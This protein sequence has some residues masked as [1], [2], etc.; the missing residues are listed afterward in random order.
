[1]LR[2]PDRNSAHAIL[3][4]R[5]SPVPKP[6]EPAVRM[7]MP[8]CAFWASLAASGR[9]LSTGDPEK[10]A[11]DEPSAVSSRGIGPLDR[12]SRLVKVVERPGL[13]RGPVEHLTA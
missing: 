1:M 11:P 8:A 4:C 7:I 10:A 12:L 6:Q 13:L 9:G 5:T 3:L 2:G